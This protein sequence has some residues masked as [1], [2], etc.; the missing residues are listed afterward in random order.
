MSMTVPSRYF[1]CLNLM[2][3]KVVYYYSYKQKLV[4]IHVQAPQ[5]V[6]ANLC[7]LTIELFI[8]IT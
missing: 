1:F 5:I 4:N 2:K 8:T 7:Y 3:K 6:V